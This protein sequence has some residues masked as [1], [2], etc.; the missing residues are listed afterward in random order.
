MSLYPLDAVRNAAVDR[1]VELLLEDV[2]EDVLAFPFSAEEDDAE[3]EEVLEAYDLAR[4]RLNVLASLLADLRERYGVDISAGLGFLPV[5]LAR[6]GLRVATTEVE[7]RR[8]RFAAHHEIQVLPYRLGSS[9]PPFSESSLDFLVLAEVL[10]H[11]KLSPIPVLRELVSLLRPGGRFVLTTPNVARLPHLEALA[12]GENFLEPFPESLSLDEDA[13][14]YVEHVREYSVREV[15]DAAEA[16]GL[17][18]DRVVM[19][20][21]GD[22]GYHPLPNPY[23]NDIIVLLAHK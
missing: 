6:S 14:N 23:A 8:A 3:V 13:T 15:I 22:S 12:A 18:I 17:E 2:R 19:T 4:P 16:V 10:E 11:L 9:P 21:W 1:E 5:V 7:P 20:G